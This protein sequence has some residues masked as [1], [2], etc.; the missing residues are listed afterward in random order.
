MLAECVR[1]LENEAGISIAYT[2]QEHFDD[3]AG[4]SA[5]GRSS[6]D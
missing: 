1:L 3:S 5:P 4:A 2:D 6:C